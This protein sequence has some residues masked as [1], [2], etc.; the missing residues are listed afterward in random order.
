MSRD[1]IRFF[2]I[3]LTIGYRTQRLAQFKLQDDGSTA[4]VQVLG[5]VFG[6]VYLE[7][8]LKLN[9]L[10][11]AVFRLKTSRTKEFFPFFRIDRQLINTE[12]V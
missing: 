7:W 11:T 4:A 1:L 8:V 10:V 5:A 2:I 6:E 3:F 12:Q 9:L